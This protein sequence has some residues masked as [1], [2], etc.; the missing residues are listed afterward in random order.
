MNDYRFIVA[1]DEDGSFH[2]L[3]YDNSKLVAIIPYYHNN[4]I[5]SIGF[6]KCEEFLENTQLSYIDNG[7]KLISQF[8]ILTS[9]HKGLQFEKCEEIDD[10]LC[11]G[12]DVY[13]VTEDDSITVCDTITCK[14]NANF[15]EGEGKGQ[16]FSGS[17]ESYI[18]FC[19]NDMVIQEG[20]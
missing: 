18:Q 19:F 9:Y 11:V 2:M 15:V 14:H 1:K 8:D 6:A 5:S 4:H 13:L 17:K 12:F 3:V 10:L 16:L 20:I 7:I